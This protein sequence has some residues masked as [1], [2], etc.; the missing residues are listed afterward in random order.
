MVN[1]SDVYIIDVKGDLEYRNRKHGV[2]VSVA[3]GQYL[4]LNKS[5]RDMYNDFKIYAS[6]YDFLE[7]VDRFV[8]CSTLHKF[9]QDRLIK[10]VGNLTRDDMLIILNKVKNYKRM[11]E[12]EKD[13]FIP[14]LNAWLLK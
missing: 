10:K 6:N 3:N 2:C 5:H 9:D 4:F 8:A 7:S 12:A 14:E 11:D 1:I 13:K